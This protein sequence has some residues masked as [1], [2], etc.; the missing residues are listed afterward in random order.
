LAYSVL[1]NFHK[2]VPSTRA[3]INTL[4]VIAQQKVATALSPGYSAT[5]YLALWDIAERQNIPSWSRWA[6]TATAAMVDQSP[7]VFG[8]KLQNHYQIVNDIAVY[9]L[10]GLLH[11]H[12]VIGRPFLDSL[13]QYQAHDGGYGLLSLQTFDPQFTRQL[14]QFHPHHSFRMKALVLKVDA[15][16]LLN[17]TFT[18]TTPV[19]PDLI[20]SFMGLRALQLMDVPVPRNLMEYFRQQPPADTLSPAQYYDFERARLALGMHLP[21]RISVP[22]SYS[23]SMPMLYS[24]RVATLEGSISPRQRSRLGH[25]ITQ[26]LKQQ[27]AAPAL[28]PRE[29]SRQM[30]VDYNLARTLQ[31]LD[32]DHAKA[33]PQLRQKLTRYLTHALRVMNSSEPLESVYDSVWLSQWANIDRSQIN[34]LART[35]LAADHRPQGGYAIPGDTPT[36]VSIYYGLMLRHD[37]Q[38]SRRKK[39]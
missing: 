36:M 7:D 39:I 15:S 20:D 6:R 14:L 9:R 34:H 16:Q 18:A 38:V 33:T 31:T 35:V 12:V 17:G 23:P 5:I 26:E 19:S 24:T 25:V 21:R 22:I 8:S 13:R 4:K 10:D 37:I 3:E 11:H 30:F 2:Q 32:G 29:L 27:L 28:T 1:A